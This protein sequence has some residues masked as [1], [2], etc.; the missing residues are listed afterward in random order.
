MDSLAGLAAASDT[1]T[2]DDY[3]EERLGTIEREIHTAA[4][5]VR[6]SMNAAL[7]AIALRNPVLKKKALS[8]AKRIGKVVVDHGETGCKTPD[9][10]EYVERAELH[11][12]KRELTC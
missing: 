12:R 4:N 2:P 11:A 3:W 9:A 7:I 8:A 1:S 6:Y 5:R 10:A